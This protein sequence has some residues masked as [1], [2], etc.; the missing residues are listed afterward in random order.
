MRTLRIGLLF[1]ALAS[2]A[3][4]CSLSP[5]EN[6]GNSHQREQAQAPAYSGFH[7][8]VMPPVNQKKPAAAP[9][10][11]GT[12]GYY[13]GKVISSAKIYNIYWGNA[14]S[15]QP[16]LDQFT[17]AVPN[18]SY[19]DWLS[20]YDTPTQT[21][22][23]GSFGGS[24]VDT[25]APAGAT[26]D[27]SQIQAELIALINAG[28]LPPPDGNNLYMF[29]FPNGVNITASGVGSSCS[30]F[31][32]YHETFVSGT[33]ELYYG[34]LPDPAT[35]G[36][37]CDN[38]NGN[39]FADLTSVT[40]HE[41]TEAV[42]DPEVGLAIIASQDSGTYPIFPN[43][44]TSA[45]G[46]IG[47]LCAWQ[48]ATVDGFN[49]QLEW[50]NAQGGCVSSG[51]SNVDAGPPDSGPVDSGSDSAVTN[52]DAGVDAT[53]DVGVDA[54]ADVGVVDAGVDAAP[55]AVAA[56]AGPGCAHAICTAGGALTGSCDPCATQVC[57][58]DPYC[59]NTAWDSI[60]VSEVTSICGD[61]CP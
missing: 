42:T 7:G 28:K 60:C 25:S 26:I 61:S 1:P 8:H 20:E 39:Y 37:N 40:T 31:C 30:S 49:V 55:D 32:G 14:G 35:C 5:G 10:V 6:V 34:V 56:D 46:E 33:E 50:S 52:N 12:L 13:G 43:G 29:F 27:D 2:L 16:Q 36:A 18:S 48:N 19:M 57:G 38:Q 47:D 4:A 54:G 22:G 53:P 51:P 9:L 3:F 15:Y 58:Q 23:R 24:V 44:W 17:Q 21:V 45:T 11:A 59:C 41:I